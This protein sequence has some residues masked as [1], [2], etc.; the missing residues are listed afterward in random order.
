MNSQSFYDEDNAVK[1]IR[2]TLPEDFRNR[3]E[4]DEILY[5][6]DCIWD[7]YE[8]KGLLSFDNIDADEELLDTTE[9]VAFVK[10]EISRI[11][12]L[13]IDARHIEPIVK[14]ELAYE[15]SLEDII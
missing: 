4:D 1:F 10:K 2:A 11:E 6:V 3:Y 5:I 15:E 7:Y 12:D 13:D 14:G 8:K 9:L